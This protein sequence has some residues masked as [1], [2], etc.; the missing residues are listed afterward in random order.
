MRTYGH[1]RRSSRLVQ[2]HRQ[3]QTVHSLLHNVCNLEN[4][5]GLSQLSYTELNMF[6]CVNHVALLEFDAVVFI[7]SLDAAKL[8]RPWLL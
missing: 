8:R 5:A 7:A 3:R 4:G 6:R 1:L 2:V